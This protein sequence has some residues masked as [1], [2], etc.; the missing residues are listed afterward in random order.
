MRPTYQLQRLSD[1]AE[2]MRQ[3]RDR[4]ATAR[5]RFY[6]ERYEGM[7]TG[8]Q[9]ELDR[10][11]VVDKATV[12]DRFDD[13]VTDQ[14]LTLAAV[15]THLDGLTRDE[16]LLGRYRAMATGGSTGRK[17]VF[18]VDRAEWRQYLAGFFRWNHYVGLK[19]R[20]PRRLRIASI[21]AARP[22]T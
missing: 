22:C 2:A 17:G 16:L 4:H 5:S 11:P 20:L 3:A 13:L 19:P 6:R 21:A 7:G 18:V 10:L 15:E 14:R 9:V 8:D 12:M 1:M